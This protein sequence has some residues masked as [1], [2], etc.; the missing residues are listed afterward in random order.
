MWNKH[1]LVLSKFSRKNHLEGYVKQKSLSVI[2]ILYQSHLAR[3][4]KQ[5]SVS[6]IEI[7]YQN[8]LARYM[9]Q[10]SVSVIEILLSSEVLRNVDWQL[11]PDV[12]EQL[13]GPIFTS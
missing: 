9:K 10:T 13:I 4:M 2:E 1:P 8:N 7:L 5:T 3:Y 6:V 11:I 12:S